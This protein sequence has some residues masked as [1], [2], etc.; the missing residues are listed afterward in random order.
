MGNDTVENA[1]KSNYHFVDNKAKVIR[2]YQ[3]NKKN[4]KKIG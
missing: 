4:T 3:P 2:Y 1:V